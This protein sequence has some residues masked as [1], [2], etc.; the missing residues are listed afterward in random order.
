MRRVSAVLEA[1]AGDDIY[2]MHEGVAVFL[3]VKLDKV[4]SFFMY[5]LGDD[6][7]LSLDCKHGV[8]HFTKPEAAKCF[9]IQAV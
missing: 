3:G 4:K 2:Q 8:G 7:V 1:I 5:D 9:G 6:L